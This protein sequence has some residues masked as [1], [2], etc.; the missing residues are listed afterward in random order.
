MGQRGHRH[1][2]PRRPVPGSSSGWRAGTHRLAPA[3]NKQGQVLCVLWPCY[4]SSVHSLGEPV[5]V[6]WCPHSPSMNAQASPRVVPQAGMPPAT[7]P[8]ALP[9]LHSCSATRKGFGANRNENIQPRKWLHRLGHWELVAI[10]R[11]VGFS[12]VRCL[13]PY[14]Q[15]I[16]KT[17]ADLQPA[18]AAG[19]PSSAWPEGGDGGICVFPG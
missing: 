8:S 15:A 5:S 4:G 14:K 2:S 7:C 19:S 3:V 11:E 9:S 16:E 6:L 13:H 18:P 10:W 12:L 17:E 1:G